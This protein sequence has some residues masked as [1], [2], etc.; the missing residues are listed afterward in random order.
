MPESKPRPAR[1]PL[2]TVLLGLV[3]LAVL[4]GAVV[5]I[6]STLSSMGYLPAG[7]SFN[8]PAPSTAPQ[9]TMPMPTMPITAPRPTAPVAAPARFDVSYI[10]ADF[11]TA[12]IVHP[13]HIARAPVLAQLKLD[14][15]LAPIIKEI[16]VDPRNLEEV[17]L[18]LDPAPPEPPKK[19]PKEAASDLPVMP[20]AI[21]RFVSKV[22]G[23]RLLG[24]ALGGVDKTTFQDMTYYRSK[25]MDFARSLVAGYVADERTLLIAPEP[26][27]HKMLTASEVKS[28]LVERLRATEVNHDVVVVSVLEPANFKTLL[29]ELLKP[30]KTAQAEY[31]VAATLPDRLQAATLTLDLG[32]STM[33]T[34]ALDAVNE[35]AAKA[36]EEQV[37]NARTRLWRE[38]PDM[39]KNL[40]KQLSPDLAEP[41]LTVADQVVPAIYPKKEGTRV[42]VTVLM[43][44]AL[45]GLM[46]KLGAVLQKMQEPAPPPKPVKE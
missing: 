2:V 33:L 7:L 28:N 18:L 8:Q 32:G 11:N 26:T 22:D 21:F 27:L 39:R 20:A 10:A 16:G 42:T 40:A 44:Q 5:V 36:L 17:V 34:L 24:E 13:R 43:P 38:W 46:H 23:P 19:D 29:G 41:V 37:K 15:L 1:H 4:G 31:A 25:T 12:V 6:V 9:P 45:P 3:L 30:I 35:E 14:Q